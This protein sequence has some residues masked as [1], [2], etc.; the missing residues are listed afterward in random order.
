[1][2]L[3]SR[4]AR[5]LAENRTWIIALAALALAV[6]TAWFQVS[7]W[8]MQ[9]EHNRLSVRPFLQVGRYLTPDPSRSRI[10]LYL[11]NDGVGVALLKRLHVEIH[12]KGITT[13]LQADIEQA[14]DES[15][16]MA[17][18]NTLWKGRHADFPNA[19]IKAS[20]APALRAGGPSVC[21]GFPQ[22]YT[23]WRSR[24]R[25]MSY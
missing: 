17:A 15:G 25:C 24:E 10:G 13:E 23:L 16:P 3:R 20:L 6:S 9:Q 12:A 5:W 1:M 7:N 2:I 8:R 22:S 4:V 21:L 14:M 11:T 18:L 19:K